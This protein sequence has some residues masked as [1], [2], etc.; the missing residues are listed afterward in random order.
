MLVKFENLTVTSVNA[1]AAAGKNFGEFLVTDGT[2]DMR[3]DDSGTWDNVYTT[4]STDTGLVYLRV[5]TGISSLQ[6]L[7]YFSFLNW[8]LE[9]RTEDD[10]GDVTTSI[11]YT[12]AAAGDIA[13]HQNYPNPFTAETGTSIRFDLSRQAQ[14][15]LRLYDM[16]GRQVATLLSGSHPAGSYTVRFAMPAL[17]AGIYLYNLAVD[18]I[19]RTARMIVTR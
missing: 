11:E 14:V 19:S 2:G 18:G 8:K 5:G 6:G 1:D 15:S 3:V 10:F 7:M 9:P 4:D 13:L 17:P 12:P 16:T